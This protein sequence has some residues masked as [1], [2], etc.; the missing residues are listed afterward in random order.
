[1]QISWMTC[2]VRGPSNRKDLLLIAVKLFNVLFS[3]RSAEMYEGKIT[4]YSVHPGAVKTEL[5]RE[6]KFFRFVGSCLGFMF[7][8]E[9]QGALTTIYCAVSYKAG[10]ETGLYYADS[11]VA[12]PSKLAK[13]AQL[14]ERLWKASC[15][16]LDIQ[17]EV[18]ASRLRL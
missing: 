4:V 6:N 1:M 2:R 9:R 18:D 5:G 10:E 13:D 16:Y 14:A 3:K 11:K 12:E 8:T 15:D 7:K 17:C